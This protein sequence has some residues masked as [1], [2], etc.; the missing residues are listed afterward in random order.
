MLGCPSGKKKHSWQMHGI[1][2]TIF[3][4]I[5]TGRDEQ[6][7][8]CLEGKC[9]RFHFHKKRSMWSSTDTWEW[10]IRNDDGRE[11]LAF[12]FA[13]SPSITE[14]WSIRANKQTNIYVFLLCFALFCFA[15][16]CFAFSCIMYGC[17]TIPVIFEV[18]AFV[19]KCV[20]CACVCVCMCWCTNM[21]LLVCACPFA[22]TSW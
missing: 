8:T 1:R 4:K 2:L 9:R 11:Q 18:G 10:E 12:Y 14:C 17:I 16:L 6:N 20:S 19:C 3:I 7:K 13:T 21:L 22:C 15:L 5:R